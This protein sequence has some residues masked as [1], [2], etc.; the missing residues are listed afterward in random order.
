MRS[1]GFE[2]IVHRYCLLGPVG[3]CVARLQDYID[4]GARHIIFSVACPKDD[5]ARHIETIARE[6]IPHFSPN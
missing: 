6:I 1:G 2:E 3:S 4:A 5:R